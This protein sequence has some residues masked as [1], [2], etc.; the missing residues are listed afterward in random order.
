MLIFKVI[1]CLRVNTDKTKHALS[2]FLLRKEEIKLRSQISMCV[3][4]AST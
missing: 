4:Q 2:P 1:M 3:N